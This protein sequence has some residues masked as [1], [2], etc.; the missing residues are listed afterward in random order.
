MKTYPKRGDRCMTQLAKM[1]IDP[2]FVVLTADL[3]RIEVVRKIFLG[4]SPSHSPPISR[5]YVASA[6][7]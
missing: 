1:S 6:V 2:K 3:F 7:A 5:A 4:E